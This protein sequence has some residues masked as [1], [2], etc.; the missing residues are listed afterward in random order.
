[1][2]GTFLNQILS[3]MKRLLKKRQIFRN[4]VQQQEDLD[5]EVEELLKISP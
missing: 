1:M 5:E 2:E 4:Q 3:Q